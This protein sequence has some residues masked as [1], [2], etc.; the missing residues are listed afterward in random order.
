MI[1]SRR[2]NFNQSPRSSARIARERLMNDS[3]MRCRGPVN[4]DSP[5]PSLSS[6]F[7]AAGAPC[8]L[9]EA[10][11]LSPIEQK[12]QAMKIA[13]GFKH[14]YLANIVYQADSQMTIATL[15]GSQQQN[16]YQIRV[17]A[18]GN[19]IVS[20]C[21]STPTSPLGRMLVWMG[22]CVIPMIGLIIFFVL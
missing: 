14:C 12:H 19:V 6:V 11:V 5:S 16:A 1:N 22:V 20:C 4:A 7:P 2:T 13:R 9:L 8:S 3:T 15:K 18:A 17:D 21:H 10:T